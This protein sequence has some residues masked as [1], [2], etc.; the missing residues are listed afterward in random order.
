MLLIW[1]VRSGKFSL[2]CA[3]VVPVEV[4][5]GPTCVASTCCDVLSDGPCCL[6]IWVVRSGEGSSQDRPLSFLVEV[7]P[8]S[9]LFRATVVLPLWFEVCHFVGLCSGDVLPRWLLVLLVEVLPK[10]VCLGISGQGVVPLAVRLATALASLSH[11]F[12]VS[13]LCW[14][15]F[16]CPH[17]SGGLLH[18]LMPDV[19]SLMVVW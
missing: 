17:G 7:L 3:L 6:V 8:K 4:L 12:H 18:F 16:V 11:H 9:V 14:W 13:Q 10:A 2:N 15:D 5:P 1:L 19:L